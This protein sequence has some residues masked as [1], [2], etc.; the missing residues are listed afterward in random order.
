MQK[1]RG[2]LQ[3]VG[4]LRPDEPVGA[5]RPLPELLRQLATDTATLVRQE[6][7]LA[8]AE[9]S[10]KGRQAAASGG[11]FGAAAAFALGAFGALTA[12]I[13]AA[14]ALVMPLWAAALI[15]TAIYAGIAAIAASRG[16]AALKELTPPVPQQ[17][18][19]SVRRDVEAVRAGVKRGQ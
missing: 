19:A 14:L 17:T 6:M 15:V 12:A 16:K 13:I 10:Q 3:W 9:L 7:E 18:V 8:R 5:D 1:R 2:R 4:L 11:Q